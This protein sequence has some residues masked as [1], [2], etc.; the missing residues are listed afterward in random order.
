MGSQRDIYGDRRPYKRIKKESAEVPEDKEAREAAAKA[1]QFVSL[2]H[3]DVYQHTSAQVN[4]T[5]NIYSPLSLSLSLTLRSSSFRARPSQTLRL[6]KTLHPSPVLTPTRSH[7]PS[8]LRPRTRA[9]FLPRQEMVG[10]RQVSSSYS[11]S[12]ISIFLN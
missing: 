6:S 8:H 2:L 11:S 4:V 3:S 5:Q 10:E 9:P 12:S 7:S 1:R